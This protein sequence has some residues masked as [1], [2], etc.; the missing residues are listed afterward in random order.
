MKLP[1][2][3]IVGRPN[4]GKSTFF[5]RMIRRRQAIVHDEPGVTRDRHY[6]TS[7]WSGRHFMMIDTGGY[8]PESSDLIDAAIREQVEI[9]VEE[10]DAV[11]L[12]TDAITGITDI[13]NEMA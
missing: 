13:D 11:I 4:V 1:V 3:A 12:M 9:A 10:A 8:I 6:A 5:N 2:V 7:D